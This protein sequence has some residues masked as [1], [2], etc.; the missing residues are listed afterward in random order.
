MTISEF[1]S[2]LNRCKSPEDRKKV[3]TKEYLLIEKVYTFH[4]SISET[5]G[6]V[7]V[8]DLYDEFGIRI[9]KDMLPTAEKAQALEE[10]IHAIKQELS[11]LLDQYQDLKK[12]VI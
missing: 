8:A 2:I 9:F 10:D 3:T 12:G 11:N 6:K 1:E 5:H 7:Q 4:P